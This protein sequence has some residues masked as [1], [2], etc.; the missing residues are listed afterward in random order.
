MILKLQWKYFNLFNLEDNEIF[1]GELP[2][3]VCI[4]IDI[5]AC[6]DNEKNKENYVRKIIIDYQIYIIKKNIYF[7]NQNNKLKKN[8][9][10][11]NKY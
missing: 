8:I 5:I 9:I 11:Y 4:F 6:H 7:N 1:I 3:N 2:I 10:F